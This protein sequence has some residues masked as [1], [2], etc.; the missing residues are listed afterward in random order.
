M[1]GASG[2][3]GLTRAERLGE[4][5][6]PLLPPDQRRE[7]EKMDDLKRV[8]AKESQKLLLFRE[9]EGKEG[10][11]KPKSISLDSMD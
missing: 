4:P 6:L 7:K 2:D 3:D 1:I 8:A 9:E 11:R 5:V 10:E